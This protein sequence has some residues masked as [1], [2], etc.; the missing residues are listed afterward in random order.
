MRAKTIC[1]FLLTGFIFFSCSNEKNSESS[2]GEIKNSE[3]KI[4]ESDLTTTSPSIS[5]GEGIVG[6]WSLAWEAYD[7]N[8]N[9]QLDEEERKKGWANHYFYKFNADGSCGIDTRPTK[10]PMVKGRYEFKNENGLQNLKVFMFEEGKEQIESQY[11][12]IELKE[13]SMLLLNSL[14]HTFWEF[15]RM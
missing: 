3:G 7:D 5:K 12:V 14:G 10:N 11:V 4:N 13:S 15:K 9:K 6:E 2:T 8:S 1:K